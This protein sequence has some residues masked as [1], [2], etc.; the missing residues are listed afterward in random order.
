LGNTESGIYLTT[1]P[2]HNTISGDNPGD[3]NTVGFNADQGVVF[4]SSGTDNNVVEGNYIGADSTGMLNFGQGHNG[5]Y[6]T[7][8]AQD[9][10]VG[11]GNI[12]AY[13]S[14][15]GVRVNGGDTNGN[16][17]TQNSIFTN[18]HGINLDNGG[19]EDTPAPTITSVSFES[20]GTVEIEGTACNGCLVE[21][22]SNGDND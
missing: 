9:N 7:A 10:T 1:G 15:D 2:H 17:I 22:F 21:V 18:T 11:Q 6:I 14:W 8:D 13:N 5:A 4:A 3:A 19:N 16:V 12:I 20:D